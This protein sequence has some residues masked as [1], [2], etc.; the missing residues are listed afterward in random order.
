MRLDFIWDREGP[1]DE[2][3][4]VANV[5]HVTT[6]HERSK[7]PVYSLPKKFFWRETTGTG[8]KGRGFEPHQDQN[9]FFATATSLVMN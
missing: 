2:N 6:P 1:D 3:D 7:A 4:F 9:F 8:P 5:V